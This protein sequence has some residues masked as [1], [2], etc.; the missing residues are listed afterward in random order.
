MSRK[1]TR[2]DVNFC[3]DMVL[4][5]LFVLL[6]CCSVIVEF[7]FPRG[8]EAGGWRLWSFGYS[9]WS[10]FQFGVLSALAAAV[11]LH[12]MLHWSWVCGVV[13]N[14]LGFRKSAGVANDDPNRTLWGVGL[15]ILLFNLVGAIVAVAVLTIQSPVVAR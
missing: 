11:L 9:Q 8:P 3:L 12:L 4:L 6:I 1:W 10:R 2:T 13:A 7:V 5:C 14:R 15:L